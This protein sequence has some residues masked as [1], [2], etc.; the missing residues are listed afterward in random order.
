MR[1]VVVKL[2]INALAQV[3]VVVVVVVVGRGVVKAVGQVDTTALTREAGPGRV[4]WT[5]IAPIHRT[6]WVWFCQV[7]V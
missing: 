1:V 6:S 4:P 5:S 7:H 2:A 3:V